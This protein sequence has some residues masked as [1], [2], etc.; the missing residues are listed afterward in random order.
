MDP[1]DLDHLLYNLSAGDRADYSAPVPVSTLQPGTV[2]RKA[3]YDRH[4]VTAAPT[5]LRDGYV[6]LTV[7]SLYGGHTLRLKRQGGSVVDIYRDRLKTSDLI[8]VPCV[9][10]VFI[11]DA[12]DAGDRIVYH[13]RAGVSLSNNWMYIHDGHGWT[14]QSTGDR[15]RDMR[16]LISKTTGMAADGWFTY[17]PAGHAP[18]LYVDGQPIPARTI[19]AMRTGDV[20]RTPG[21]GRLTVLGIEA[22]SNAMRLVTVVTDPTT[23]PGTQ[24]IGSRTRGAVLESFD[25]HG[26]ALFPVEPRP[27]ELLTASQLHIGDTVIMASG[28]RRSSIAHITDVAGQ[29]LSGPMH[30]YSTTDDGQEHRHLTGLHPQYALLHRAS[31][32][33]LA[34]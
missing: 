8:K 33:A 24:V 17:V 12:P 4:I 14:V 30:V 6:Q 13:N 9:P 18:H 25:H 21:G 23:L 22:I 31:V 1:I 16:S 32:Q 2:L 19:R 15:V 3:T 28:G 7:R 5:P 10:K 11:P 26:I 34:A 29:P 27:A 20:V